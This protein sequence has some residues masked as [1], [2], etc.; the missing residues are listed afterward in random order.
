MIITT[1]TLLIVTSFMK[2]HLKN[3]FF[4]FQW[5]Q[6]LSLA[7]WFSCPF[8]RY[9][10]M[11]SSWDL[12]L[13]ILHAHRELALKWLQGAFLTSSSFGSRSLTAIPEAVNLA[14]EEWEPPDD[15]KGGEGSHRPSWFFPISPS[16][17]RSV[18]PAKKNTHYQ[19]TI[20]KAFL[21][22]NQKSF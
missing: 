8:L 21:K 4:M 14:A 15:T 17:S 20:S 2:Q 1:T 3:F 19:Q 18:F 10:T 5:F 22:W 11:S 6:N 9:L 7:L 16:H 12:D 13:Y